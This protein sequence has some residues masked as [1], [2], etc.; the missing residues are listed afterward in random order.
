MNNSISLAISNDQ[1]AINYQL[2]ISDVAQ[3]R[4]SQIANALKIVNYK[5][6]IKETEGS[7]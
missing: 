1:L 4:Q 6:I 3:N 2:P 7:V 5:L